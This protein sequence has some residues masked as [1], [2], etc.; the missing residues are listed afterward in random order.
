MLPLHERVLRFEAVP[1]ISAGSKDAAIR[2]E[3]GFSPARYYQVLNS[4]IDEPAAVRFDPQLV[5]RL[6]RARERRLR[7]HAERRLG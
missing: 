6:H 3:F 7:A 2:E 1:R 4:L 5:G